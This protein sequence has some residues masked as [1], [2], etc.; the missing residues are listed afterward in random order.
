MYICY[1]VFLLLQQKY[2]SIFLLSLS[3]FAEILY[4]TLF[5]NKK[6]IITCLSVKYK[7]QIYTLYITFKQEIHYR[8]HTYV[9]EFFFLFKPVY[10]YWSFLRHIPLHYMKSTMTA[11]H[12]SVCEFWIFRHSNTNMHRF[13]NV[14]GWRVNRII[15][16]V[17][18][19]FLKSWP[20]SFIYNRA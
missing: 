8:Q 1:F 11:H 6:H 17:R 5:D 2:L 13:R 19:L 10:I 15:L 3:F 14:S 18:V 20:S 7:Q 9:S 4:S 12:I 16:F